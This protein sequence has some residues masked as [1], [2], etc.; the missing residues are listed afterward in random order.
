MVMTYLKDGNEI[1]DNIPVIIIK[2]ILP[3]LQHFVS[4]DLINGA[5]VFKYKV[6]HIICGIPSRYHIAWDKPH[7]EA[8][9]RAGLTPGRQSDCC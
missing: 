6:H 8:K 3:Q 5:P 4:G 7:F 9:F 2:F 1:F